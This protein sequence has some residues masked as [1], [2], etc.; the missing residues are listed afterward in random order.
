M[1][2]AYKPPRF[3]FKPTE[4]ELLLHALIG[5][6]DEE[7]A[8][9]LCL[10]PNTLKK[11]WQSIYARV[12]AVAPEIFG[13]TAIRGT[14]ARRGTEKRRNVMEYIRHHLEEVRPVESPAEETR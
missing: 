5:E 12:E 9:I 1:I 8:Q 13:V 14:E 2:F 3:Y 6:T 11:R 7:L 4:Q 10:S